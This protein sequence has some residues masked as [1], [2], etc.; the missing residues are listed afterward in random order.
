[1]LDTLIFLFSKF[2]KLIWENKIWARS[3]YHIVYAVEYRLKLFNLY[4]VIWFCSGI[5]KSIYMN[6]NEIVNI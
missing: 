1:M 4:L 6:V 5:E 3:Y 2:I